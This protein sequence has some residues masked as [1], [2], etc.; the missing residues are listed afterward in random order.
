MIRVTSYVTLSAEHRHF[1]PKTEQP[2][3]AISL[4]NNGAQPKHHFR[5]PMLYPFE[6]R[7][8]AIQT[9]FGSIC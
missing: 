5:N 4:K 2:A 8:L 9:T 1:V 7:A 6:L 3:R